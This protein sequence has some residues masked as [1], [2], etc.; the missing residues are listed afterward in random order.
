MNPLRKV[1]ASSVRV[2]GW[3]LRLYPREFRSE[4]GPE[5]MQALQDRCRNEL[6]GASITK[7]IGVWGT[8]LSDLIMSVPLE[9]LKK[10]K[11]MNRRYLTN[12]MGLLIIL[13]S[14][15]AAL[16]WYQQRSRKTKAHVVDIFLRPS[17]APLTPGT[18]C[19]SGPMQASEKA[20]LL[21]IEGIRS[22]TPVLSCLE[23]KDG[24]TLVL[25]IDLQSYT[26]EVGEF[27][28]L[29]GR[30]FGSSTADE[31]L[32]DDIYA[33]KKGLRVGDSYILNG[34]SFRVCGVVRHGAG[35][36][37][38]APIETLQGMMG[39]K[40]SASWMLIRCENRSQI[41]TVIRSIQ[42]KG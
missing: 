34:S 8:V 40:G 16:Y 31:I 22:V 29:A 21:K 19:W 24:L 42:A 17:N 2:Y 1:I 3:L 20:K 10:G 12:G 38:F 15:S 14:V 33:S 36:R 39:G 23:I 13:V 37:I 7:A 35:A 27:T 26:Q 9:H 18:N 30:Q 41:E 28:Y 5:M 4:Y 25:G 32:V 11:I 6:A